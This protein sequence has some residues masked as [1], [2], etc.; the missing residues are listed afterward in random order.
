MRHKMD[1]LR[2]NEALYRARTYLQD[3]VEIL[4]ENGYPTDLIECVTKSSEQCEAIAELQEIME[5]MMGN[6]M[7]PV[8][9]PRRLQMDS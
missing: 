4:R 5:V 9:P 3:Y 6:K 1:D 8:P 2:P 7:P